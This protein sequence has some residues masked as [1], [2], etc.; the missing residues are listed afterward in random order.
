MKK[1]DKVP[2]IEPNPQTAWQD[3]QLLRTKINEIISVINGESEVSGKTKEEK[4]AVLR[5]KLEVAL[6]ENDYLQVGVYTNRISELEK[7]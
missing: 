2:R 5:A 6:Q 3:V 1:V 4:I 7:E